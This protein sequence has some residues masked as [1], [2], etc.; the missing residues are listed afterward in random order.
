M[1]GNRE[2]RERYIARHY[3]TISR[4]AAQ[5]SGEYVELLREFSGCPAIK[6]AEFRSVLQT[7]FEKLFRDPKIPRKDFTEALD[8]FLKKDIKL[9]HTCTMTT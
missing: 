7:H 8:T 9:A 2:L 5:G 1:Y 6:S 3:P 4:E